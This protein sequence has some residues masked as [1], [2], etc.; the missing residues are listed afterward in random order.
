VRKLLAKAAG[1]EVSGT[2]RLDL[3]GKVPFRAELAFRRFNPASFGDY[4][5]GSISGTAS[6][7]G[8]LAAEREIDARWTVAGSELNGLP[9]E[10]TGSARIAG[11]RVLQ[12][13]IE[14]RLGQTR[15]SAHGAFGRPGDELVWTMSS[16]RLAEIDP[17]IE[18]KVRASGVLSG[19]WENPQGRF[20]ALAEGC[21]SAGAALHG[22]QRPARGQPR[23]ARGGDRAARPRPRPRAS[24]CAAA[25]ARRGGRASCAPP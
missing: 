5:E 24:T 4:P 19:S 8:R 6:L 2:G 21:R 17:R 1:G 12:A 15:A 7:A 16:A 11:K 23:A 10:S 20:D 14:S 9:L 22:G 25:G 18:G 13:R 3:R